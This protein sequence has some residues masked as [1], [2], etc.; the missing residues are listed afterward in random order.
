MWGFGHGTDWRVSWGTWSINCFPASQCLA[1]RFLRSLWSLFVFVEEP[2]SSAGTHP[3]LIVKR[4]YYD[5]LCILYTYTYILLNPNCLYVT[6]GIE[7]HDILR[8]PILAFKAIPVPGE[9]PRVTSEFTKAVLCINLAINPIMMKV[10][11]M[12]SYGI[13]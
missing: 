11:K 3:Q 9:A 1:P 13:N 7:F 10:M 5:I 6:I 2:N 8:K 4:S 12:L